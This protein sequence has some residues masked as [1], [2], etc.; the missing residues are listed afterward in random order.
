MSRG[1][2]S[3][4]ILLLVGVA[5]QAQSPGEQLFEKRC[6]S[7]HNVGSGDKKGPD[8][9][10]VP[11]RRSKEWL[12]EFVKSPE[13]MNRK[14]DQPAAELFRK[15]APEVMPDQELTDE[16]IDQIM[17]VIDELTNKNEIFV[18]AGAKLVRPIVP[19]DVNAGR[20]LFTGEAALKGGGTACISCHN[21]NGIGTLGGG[22]LGPDLTAANIKYR[23]P[24]LIS[25]LQ[26]P[27]FPTMRSMFANRALSEE[28][29]VQLFAYLQDAK[30]S[31]PAAATVP[32]AA[33][34]E[35]WF[36]VV[37][38]VALVAALGGFGVAWKNRL[39]GV[40]EEM[41]RRNRL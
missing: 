23:D 24:E 28:E 39:R 2:I 3:A 32:A 1:F 33:P 31:L 17:A 15:Y 21:V 16:Q 14:G 10:G 27:N 19:T 26:T 20:Q 6:Y 9:K 30:A 29:I 38:F 4:L 36:L 41:V 34:I 13:T 5:A 25:I 40:R 7:C 22:T 8:L 12:R 35:P 11:G 37:G 18:P